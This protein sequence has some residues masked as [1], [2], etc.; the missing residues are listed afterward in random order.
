PHGSFALPQTV[1][2]LKRILHLHLAA[3]SASPQ[4][5]KQKNRRSAARA[6]Q[7]VGRLR[8][9]TKSKLG[10]GQPVTSPPAAK[11]WLN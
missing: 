9:S 7:R 5:V 2:E 11:N 10:V 8:A 4:S 3:V 6:E 1:S